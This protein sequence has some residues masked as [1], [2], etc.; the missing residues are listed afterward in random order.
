MGTIDDLIPALKRLRMSGVMETLG[1]RQKQA[2]DDELPYEEFLF[3]CNSDI[4]VS[5]RPPRTQ[6]NHFFG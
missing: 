2:V 5:R 4:D 3:G 1:L 6:G